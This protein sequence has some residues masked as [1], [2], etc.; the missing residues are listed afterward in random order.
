MAAVRCLRRVG[1]GVRRPAVRASSALAAPYASDR[2]T[3]LNPAPTCEAPV[4]SDTYPTPAFGRIA[5]AAQYVASL[6]GRDL[7]VWL[8]GE[9]VAEPA[10]HPIVAPSV[11][12]VAETSL[13]RS[14]LSLK[15]LVS[16]SDRG[17]FWARFL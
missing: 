17:L 10:A 15:A 13:R 14:L 1:G 12:A 6:K 5:T 9:R 11:N 8:L 16:R 3:S 7:A 2:Y 4:A